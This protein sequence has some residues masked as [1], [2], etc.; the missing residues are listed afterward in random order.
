MTK[1]DTSLISAPVWDIFVRCF[2]WS[3]VALFVTAVI[4]GEVGGNAIVWHMRCGY[5]ILT[6]VTFRL[7]W[8]FVGGEYARFTSF[9]TGPG[10]TIA[11]AKSMLGKGHDYV[12]GHNPLGGWMVLA[13]LLTLATQATLGLF[14]NDEIATT[15]PLAQYV[16]EAT[17]IRVTGIHH[18]LGKVL[19]VFVFLH[20]AAV[21]FH[22]FV[23][24][25]NLIR[26]MFTGK[27]SLPSELAREAEGARRASTPLGFAVFVL[28]IALVALIVNWPVWFK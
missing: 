22:L 27:K 13:L 14:T 4:S 10:K 8:G 18:I 6:L 1:P 9:L 23:K 20:V 17:S 7:I 5:A 24:K 25:E 3:L 11:F 2:H 19:L 26:A 12:V 21:L 28:V 16:S 15:G